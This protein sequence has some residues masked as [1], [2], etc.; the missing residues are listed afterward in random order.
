MGPRLGIK[1]VTPDTLCTKY[2]KH[3]WETGIYQIGIQFTKGS[4]GQVH[5]FKDKA[6]FYIHPRKS[7]NKYTLLPPLT[8]HSLWRN[9]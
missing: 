2:V 6:L 8:L 7:R 9:R 5:V 4:A 3:K 1:P